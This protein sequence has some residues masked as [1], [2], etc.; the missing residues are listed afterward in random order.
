M[1]EADFEVIALRGECARNYRHKG[2]SMKKYPEWVI[3]RAGGRRRYNAL[4][5]RARAIRRH[6][7]A[8]MTLATADTQREIARKLGVHE[9]TLSRDVSAIEAWFSPERRCPL[10][11]RSYRV[12]A[13][14]GPNCPKASH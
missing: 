12:A 14:Q 8:V 13:I 11:K 1:S 9:S 3:K 7:V 5:K 4:R 10:C 6:R 2:A